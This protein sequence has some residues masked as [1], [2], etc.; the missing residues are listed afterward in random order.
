MLLGDPIAHSLSPAIYTRAFERWTEEDRPSYN[1]WR[2]TPE[3]LSATVADLRAHAQVLGG[4]V[5]I[6]HKEAIVPLLD[7]LDERAKQIGAVNCFVRH[8][9]RLIGCNTDVPGL[10]A[11]LERAG[12]N[13]GRAVLLGAGGA[14]RACAFALAVL[15]KYELT[16]LNRTVARAEALACAIWKAGGR[17]N[18]APLQ[19][20][21]A[22][23][24]LGDTGVL[25]NA[26]SV[27]LGNP[28]AAPIDLRGAVTNAHCVIDLVYEPLETALLAAA[29]ATGATCIDG[30]EVLVEQA[31]ASIN[32]WFG[33]RA[34]VVT[35][36]Q[37][38]GA[39]LQV[40]A[41]RGER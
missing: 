18:A 38:R 4:N 29:R 16:I 12:R 39:A 6:P 33:D 20:A 31:R 35:S 26:T 10:L 15:C 19:T 13:G 14:A 34:S 8:G 28:H 22:L 1:A 7:G 27:G 40:H 23:H 25:V 11:V 41:R 9:D 32:A 21:A 2:V 5:T 30:L 17:A 37:L 3:R 24:A 36:E